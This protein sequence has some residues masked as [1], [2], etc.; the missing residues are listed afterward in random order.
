MSMLDFPVILR[1][2]LLVSRFIH[3]L[4]TFATVAEGQATGD[5]ELMT[6]LCSHWASS[7]RRGFGKIKKEKTVS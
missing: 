7:V 5:P 4:T 1:V 3:K 6:A 2:K